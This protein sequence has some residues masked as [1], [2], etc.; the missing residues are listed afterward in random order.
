MNHSGQSSSTYKEG[1]I[2][3]I[4]EYGIRFYMNIGH[5]DLWLSGIGIKSV[6]RNPS[7]NMAWIG[8]DGRGCSLLIL[9]EAFHKEKHFIV[10]G[11]KITG[12]QYG[13]CLSGISL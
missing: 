1:T 4:G 12:Q 7:S 3:A 13:K 8:Q 11:P 10:A 2:K 9:E 5:L 6:Q